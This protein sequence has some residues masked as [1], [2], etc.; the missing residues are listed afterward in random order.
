MIHEVKLSNG[1]QLFIEEL[2]ETQVLVELIDKDQE[3]VLDYH[4]LEVE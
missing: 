2:E 4:V 3:T 1:K